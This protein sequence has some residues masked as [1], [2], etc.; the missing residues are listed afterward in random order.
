MIAGGGHANI[1]SRWDFRSERPAAA[2][3]MDA[4][5]RLVS[6]N[7]KTPNGAHVGD[8][9]MAI[10]HTCEL[11][12]VEAFEYLTVLQRHLDA[13]K[14]APG[15]WLPW[16]YRD[17]LHGAPALAPPDHRV[18]LQPARRAPGGILRHQAGI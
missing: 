7:Y 18:R 10:V 14:A 8:V 9:F 1:R 6:S 2:Q 17:T 15:A 12:G 4:T 16:T 3:W 5:V 13:I 11:N